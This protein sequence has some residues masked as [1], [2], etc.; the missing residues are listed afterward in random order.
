M[1]GQRRHVPKGAPRR[2]PPVLCSRELQA[3]SFA[4]LTPIKDGIEEATRSFGDQRNEPERSSR[5]RGSALRPEN[6]AR[7]FA[8]ERYTGNRPEG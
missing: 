5:P 6:T 4:A 1:H 8:R 2:H 7:S 3:R